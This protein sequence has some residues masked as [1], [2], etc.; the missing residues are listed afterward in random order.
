MLRLVIR[1]SYLS[2]LLLSGTFSEAALGQDGLLGASTPVNY[3]PVAD[4]QDV[5]E[6]V[7]ENRTGS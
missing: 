6:V 7:P 3:G 1:R 4:V 2:L 5:T